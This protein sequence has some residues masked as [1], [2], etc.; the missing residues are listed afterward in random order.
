MM[1]QSR[2]SKESFDKNT[3]V[4]SLIA[5][6]MMCLAILLGELTCDLMLDRQRVS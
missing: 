6:S 1:S 2:H 5:S 3:G 4:V